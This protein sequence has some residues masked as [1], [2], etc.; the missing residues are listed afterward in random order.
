MLLLIMH[1]DKII[2]WGTPKQI[3]DLKK[4]QSRTHFKQGKNKICRFTKAEHKFTELEVEYLFN[5]PWLNQWRCKCGKKGPIEYIDKP[6]W[7]V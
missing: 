2:N 5:R 3:Q 4:N 7:L 1:G 6:K